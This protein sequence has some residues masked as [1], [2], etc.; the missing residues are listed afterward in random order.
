MPALTDAEGARLP[1]ALPEVIDAHVHLFPDR[2]FDA[3][4]R[5]FTTH[6]WPMRYRLYTPEV[7]RFLLGRGVSYV[8]ALTYAHRP[9]MAR[10]LNAYMAEVCRGEPRV[11]GLGT[12]LPG[13]PDA[14]EILAEAFAL[15]LRGVKL[16]CHVQCFA[17]DDERLYPL[18]A[19]C[20]E[21]GKPVVIHAGREP[22]SPAYK[23][24]P[25][26]LCA[27]ERIER[28]LRDHPRL[29]LCVPHL[30]ADEFGAYERLVT[31]YDNLWLDTT[32]AV[33]DFFPLTGTDHP[34]RM[35]GVRPERMMYG[36]DF[37]GL[38]YAWDREVKKIVGA[39]LGEEA[40]AA[41]LGGT[42]RRFFGIGAVDER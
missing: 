2:V 28:V 18:Y 14:V 25:Y 8:V 39:R 40:L 31:R 27:A 11:I 42:A 7:I 30:G 22:A 36:T 15:G 33:A 26:E 37:P 1:E 3:I 41:V 17:P 10:A 19:L 13:E 6:A 12:V 35:V 9:G 23:C 21:A 29:R 16:H 4:W 24:D 5:W 38:P 32:M 34:M 20:A